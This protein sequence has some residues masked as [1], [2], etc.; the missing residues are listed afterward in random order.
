MG[1]RRVDEVFLFFSVL[2]LAEMLSVL[3]EKRCSSSSGCEDGT[4]CCFKIMVC[5]QNCSEIF[6]RSDGDCVQSSCCNVGKNYCSKKACH[7]NDDPFWEPLVYATVVLVTLVF[8]G[9]CFYSCCY[10]IPCNCPGQSARNRTVSGRSNAGHD[11]TD[12]GDAGD[13]EHRGTHD[14]G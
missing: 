3:A 7:G 1:K 6:C 12:I 11:D 9:V 5:R 10:V 4:Y 2:F 8:L 14:E 13:N